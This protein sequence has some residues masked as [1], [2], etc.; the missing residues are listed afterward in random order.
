ML[1]KNLE[2]ELL[3]DKSVQFFFLKK[4]KFKIQ[5]MNQNLENSIL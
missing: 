3:F 5:K 1:K 4:I 2:F